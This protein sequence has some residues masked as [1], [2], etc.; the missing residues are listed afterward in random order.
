MTLSKDLGLLAALSEE[1]IL[2]PN[3]NCG[4]FNKMLF[5]N[6]K[7]MPGHWNLKRH[8]CGSNRTCC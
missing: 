8:H 5:S 2:L 4:T 3:G 1:D 7:L 6:K